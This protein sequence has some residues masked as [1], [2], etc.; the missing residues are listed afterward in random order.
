MRKILCSILLT[1]LVAALLASSISAGKIFGD[2]PDANLAPGTIIYFENFDNASDTD[3][4]STLQSLGWTKSEGFKT[5]TAVMTIENGQLHIDNLDETVGES[6]DSYA[7]IM[8]SDYLKNFCSGDYSY[9]YEATYREAGNT[10]RYLSLLCNYDG[11]NNYNT[12]DVRFRGDGYNQIRH[13]SDWTHYSDDEVPMGDT[14]D[15]G[16]C[17]TVFGIDFD[18][19]EYSLKDITFTVRVEM[20]KEKGPTVYVNGTKVS[21]MVKNQDQWGSINAYAIAF[22]SSTMLKADFDNLIIWAGTG[23]E[24]DTASLVT[25]EAPAA[26]A[27]AEEAPAE[28]ETPA[29]EAPVAEAAPAAP[30]AAAQTGNSAAIVILALAAAFGSAVIAKKR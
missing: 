23:V 10:Y 27:P 12:V 11:M 28:A 22:K 19:N 13:D 14:S 20:S 7:V 18:E 21:E 25:E 3:T 16:M 30:A 8:D 1:L 17:K 5:C 4:D 2:A 26:E 29:P 6:S 9:Q 15:T 24:P